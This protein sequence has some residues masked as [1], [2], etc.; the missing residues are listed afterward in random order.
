MRGESS[1]SGHPEDRN[2]SSWLLIGFGAAYL[3]FLGVFAYLASAI[4]HFPGELRT[5]VWVDSWRT[6][7]LDTVMK[8]ISAPG[9]GLTA[10]SLVGV[11]L[12]VLYLK[13]WRKEGGLILLATLVSSGV[14]LAVKEAVARPRPLPDVARVLGNLD[15]FSFPSGHVMHYVVFLGA[16]A[17]VSTWNMSPGITRGLIHIALVIALMA[18]GVSRIYLGAHWFGDV[19]GGYA[20]GAAVLAAF[21][22]IWRLWIRREAPTAGRNESGATGMQQFDYGP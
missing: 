2:L 3:V 22:G 7:W 15:G 12:T 1:D 20:F 10:W 8:A 21:V 5:V 13:G 4:D 11:A 18:V 19:V 14:N 17:A 16:L 9:F 6:S